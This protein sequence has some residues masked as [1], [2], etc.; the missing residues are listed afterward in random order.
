MTDSLSPFPESFLLGDS[1]EALDLLEV[2]SG[3]VVSGDAHPPSSKSITHRYGVLALLAAVRGDAGPWS[4]ERPLLAE[5]T[6]L[7]LGALR[8]CGLEIELEKGGGDRSVVHV[9]RPEGLFGASSGAET[10]TET[11][12]LCGN[13]GTLCRILTAVL[14]AVPGRFR[15]DGSPR[16]RERPLGALLAALEPLGAQIRCLDRQGYLPLLIEGGS[17]RGGVTEVDASES[18]QYVTALL[19]AGLGA[20]ESSR[21]RV[22]ALTSAP[23]LEITKQVITGCGGRVEQQGEDLVVWPGL[24]VPRQLV[25]ETDFSAVAYPAAAAALTAGRL[26]IHGTDPD[27]PQGDRRFLEVLQRM[28]ALVTWGDGWV[29]VQ[30]GDLRA[31]RED[32]SD[33]PDQV[34]TLA[35][36]APFAAGVTHI[37]NVAHLRIKESDRLAAMTTELRR[38]GATVE[39]LEDG[40]VIPGVW[41]SDGGSTVD[42][43]K[44]SGDIGAPTP[45]AVDTWDDHRIAM[46][47]ALTGLRRPGTQIREPAVVAKSYPRF[48]RDL[49]SWLRPENGG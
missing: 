4:L 27:S 38:L 48:W 46:S 31:V 45:V 32:F 13:A 21:I 5:D 28:G 33:I 43:S 49:E 19:L 16:L 2:P 24:S 39:E 35:A 26:R 1:E 36:L 22:K 12:V 11:E 42:S 29:E 8:A 23:Y 9:R 17:L 20:R 34:P 10:E 44:P 40:L 41:S 25:V 47:L 37:E 15:L 3:G 30:G 14:T 6:Q 7:T 18:S